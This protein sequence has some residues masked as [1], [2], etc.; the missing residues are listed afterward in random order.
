MTLF[1]LK[2]V[3]NVESVTTTQS[4]YST[5]ITDNTSSSLLLPDEVELK[6]NEILN[7][8]SIFGSENED[9]LKTIIVSQTGSVDDNSAQTIIMQNNYDNITPYHFVEL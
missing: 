6:P 5:E 9:A 3:N 7:W 2:H 4:S 8:Q 1:H